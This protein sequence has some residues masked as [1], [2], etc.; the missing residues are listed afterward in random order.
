MCLLVLVLDK[1]LGIL[2]IVLS[3]ESI[4]VASGFACDFDGSF[5]GV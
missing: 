2:F 4:V 1:T 3:F 5:C